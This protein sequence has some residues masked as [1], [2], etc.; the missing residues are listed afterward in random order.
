M[1]FT[2]LKQNQNGAMGL[3]CSIIAVINMSLLAMNLIVFYNTVLMRSV[4]EIA[5]TSTRDIIVKT[6]DGWHAINVYYGIRE[7]LPPPTIHEAW[8][9][10]QV[11]QDKMVLALTKEYQKVL[12]V[13]E[14]QRQNYFVDLA[15]NDATQMSNTYNLEKNE[16]TGLCVEPNPVYW[17]RLAHR[18]CTVVAAFVGSHDLQPVNVSLSN[19]AMAGIVGMDMDNKP[20]ADKV[21]TQK[22]TASLRSVFQRYQVPYEIDY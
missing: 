20:D 7:P 4:A 1:K 13:D 2:S 5:P 9:S 15:A 21:Y 11:G 6:P 17:E 8:E 16:W 14:Q 12:S 18:K 3:L 10:S 22:Y 19:N